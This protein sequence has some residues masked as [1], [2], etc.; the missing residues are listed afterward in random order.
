MPT[1]LVHR[2]NLILLATVSCLILAIVSNG[3]LT[4]D[5]ETA[6]PD[7]THGIKATAIEIAGKDS[8]EIDQLDRAKQQKVLL[9][10]IIDESMNDIGE[11][12]SDLRSEG[13]VETGSTNENTQ[14]AAPTTLASSTSELE[15]QGKLLMMSFYSG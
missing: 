3:A 7:K 14:S 6:P 8:S 13:I 4:R 11:E 12:S 15:S 2:E 9:A 5:D 1:I 10:S